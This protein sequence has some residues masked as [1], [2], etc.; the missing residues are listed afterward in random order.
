MET[1]RIKKTMELQFKH[2]APYLPYDLKAYIEDKQNKIIDNFSVFVFDYKCVG[3]KRYACNFH[4]D[5]LDHFQVKPILR[6]LSD[7]YKEIEHKE[8]KIIPIEVICKEMGINGKSNGEY[9]ITEEIYNGNDDVVITDDYLVIRRF[10]NETQNYLMLAE[11]EDQSNKVEFIP[12]HIY[13]L[14]FQWHFDVFGLIQEGLAVD[15]N[16]FSI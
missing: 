11:F 7:L 3:F 6:P 15:I 16:T 13:E 2:I 1:K 4:F 10:E 9:F 5:K 14:L 8:E 12:Y